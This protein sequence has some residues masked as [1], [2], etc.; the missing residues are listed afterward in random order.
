MRVR[1][2]FVLDWL[3]V[4]A[5]LATV[6]IDLSGGFFVR[7][8][9]L[10]I[11]ARSPE[12]SLLLALMLLG[13]R[14]LFAREVAFLRVSHERWGRFARWL[15]RPAAD[16][17]PRTCVAVGHRPLAAS[18][19]IFCAAGGVLLREQLRDLSL[20][21]DLG[22]PLFSIWR[23]SWVFRQLQGD[24]RPLFDANIFHP[25]RLTLTYSDAMLVPALTAA[26]LFA[27]GVHPVQVYNLL[28]LSAFLLSGLTTF[29]L[30]YRL[31]GSARGATISA[32]VFSFYPYRFEHYP[33]LELQM[34]HWMPL[35][36]LALHRFTE[37]LRF[38]DLLI[39]TV[40][41]VAQLYSSMYYGVF[42]C[43]YGFVVAG[44]SCVSR[45]VPLRH[46]LKAVALAG[47]TGLVLS[48]PLA[49]PYVE[50]QARKGSREASEVQFYSATAV[51]YLRAH[52]RSAR[53]TG[54]L[55]PA[56]PERALFPGI[57][58][59]ALAAAAVA[60]PLGA[61]RVAYL[62]GLVLAFEGSRG[63]N[64]L[65]YRFLYEYFLPVRGL[66]VPARFSLLV[67]LSLAVLAGYATR[68]LL[69]RLPGW[70][71]HVVFAA[72]VV[73]VTIDLQPRLELQSVWREPPDIYASLDRSEVVLA[74]FPFPSDPLE[75]MYH[76][77]YMYFSVWHGAAMV[78][79]YSGFS[80]PDYPE[81]SQSLAAFPEEGALL[82]LRER[83]VTHV[84]V[85][86]ALYGDACKKVLGAVAASPAL[87]LVAES[88]WQGE[89]VNLYELRSER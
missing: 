15:Y 74:E 8:G 38:R 52:D 86:C 28:L 68:R 80:P 23:V 30:V 48:A 55:L 20:V 78:N 66:R 31:T 62:A 11:S 9:E 44:V 54:R 58:P 36:L 75:L 26:P 60:P 24:P 18:V 6:I 81:L 69:R 70:R 87:H 89:V 46:L 17:V 22:D 45:R 37:A 53:Y 21:P 47:V 13:I 19:I 82:R 51:D 34:A 63:M 3:I 50:S 65:S 56:Q 57:A 16:R 76:L 64:G 7:V 49:L 72:L 10:R 77:P 85:N 39:A 42:F 61:I 79:G 40:C 14:W 41:G 43:L 29:A 4:I 88:E 84:T 5:M 25:E 59:I 67:G 12:R 71:G 33:H 2:V 73:V 35:G 32:L 83:G 1:L 27:S